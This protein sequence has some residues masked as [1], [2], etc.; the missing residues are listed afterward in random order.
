MSRIIVPRVSL[1]TRLQADAEGELT[2]SAPWLRAVWILLI[3][4]TALEALNEFGWIG[5][6]SVV[7]QRWI[8][9][10]ILAAAAGLTLTRA[11]LE[12][13][14]RKA[15][16]SFG[17]ATAVWCLG[18]VLW[19]IVYGGEVRPPY[20]TFADVL[21][22][23]WY[24]LMA[25]GMVFL[26][27]VR[28]RSFELHRWMDGIAVMLVVLV[29]GIALIVQPLTVHSSQGWLATGVSFSYPVL[30]VLL[31]GSLLGVYGLLGWKPDAMWIFIGLGI[32]A[33]TCADAAFA[34]NEARGVVESGH[35]DFVWTMGALFIAYAAWVQVPNVHHEQARVT[36]LRA[37]ALALI[38][39][40]IAIAIQILAVFK[41]IGKSERVVTALVLVVASI[42]IILT[43]P[44]S[45][46]GAE[47]SASVPDAATTG[48]KADPGSGSVSGPVRPESSRMDRA[49]G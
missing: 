7:Y 45:S 36:G 44:R 5:G 22:L 30:D 15:W 17:L 40:A 28:F 42:Q 20:P 2:V 3:V 18:T 39:Q 26:I 46:A 29:A 10:S 31:I 19:S 37:I 48:T 25:I 23:L 14:A 21:W 49:E 32:L 41:D 8:H 4:F 6:P 38:A 34:V 47:A 1:R 13:V 12:P 27:R 11:A 24:P 43:R 16:F 35:Y 9:D 33:S